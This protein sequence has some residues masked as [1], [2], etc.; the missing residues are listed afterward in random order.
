MMIKPYLSATTSLLFPA[1]LYPLLHP[2]L[3]RPTQQGHRSPSVPRQG[4]PPRWITIQS[5]VTPKDGDDNTIT[6]APCGCLGP[7]RSGPTVDLRQ[8]RLHVNDTRDGKIVTFYSEKITLQNLWHTCLQLL[9]LNQLRNYQLPS[10]DD[11]M[12]NTSVVTSAG[13][14]YD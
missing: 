14:W 12:A 9:V 7:C 5:M 6:V 2:L 8:G 13:Q 1:H 4:L 10:D 11:T 3:H